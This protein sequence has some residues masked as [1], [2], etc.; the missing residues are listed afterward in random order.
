MSFGSGYSENPE[1]VT[2]LYAV[3]RPDQPRWI[4][5]E[6]APALHPFTGVGDEW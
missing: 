1:V 5:G 2:L 4:G 6:R 3:R